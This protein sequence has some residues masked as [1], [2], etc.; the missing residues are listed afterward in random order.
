[1]F[2]LL[3]NVLGGGD[4]SSKVDRNDNDAAT[5]SGG[6]SDND[7]DEALG[8]YLSNKA[9]KF[10]HHYDLIRSETVSNS[11]TTIKNF[12]FLGTKV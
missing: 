5:S 3:S 4:T 12:S 2:S 8:K 11:T 6:S 7:L 10:L 1:M 9:E